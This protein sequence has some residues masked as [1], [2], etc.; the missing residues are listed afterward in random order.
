MHEI[1]CHVP[2]EN[3]LLPH[4][5]LEVQIL[6]L[7]H[8]TLDDH[9]CHSKMNKGQIHSKCLST[10]HW[11]RTSSINITPCASNKPHSHQFRNAQHYWGHGEPG[12]RIVSACHKLQT[13]FRRYICN[14][15][16]SEGLVLI[17]CLRLKQQSWATHLIILVPGEVLRCQD[18]PILLGATLHDPNVVDGEPALPDHLRGWKPWA[19]TRTVIPGLRWQRRDPRVSPHT[20]QYGKTRNMVLSAAARRAPH[21]TGQ[22]RSLPQ[23]GQE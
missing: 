13:G 17:R 7:T 2:S 16:W 23:K 9:S 5:R 21:S 15:Q 4:K 10:F 11:A 8:H 22:W 19:L 6:E 3:S 20:E 18:K 1:I 14:T 12:P